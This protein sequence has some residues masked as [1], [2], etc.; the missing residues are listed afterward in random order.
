MGKMY[1]YMFDIIIWF[2]SIVLEMKTN[3]I[4]CVRKSDVSASLYLCTQETLF[5]FNQLENQTMKITEPKATF[6]FLGVA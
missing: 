6:A 4:F 3:H 2:F 5:V 1:N